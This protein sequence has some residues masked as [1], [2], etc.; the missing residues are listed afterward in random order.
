[1]SEID[2][3]FKKLCLINS[4]SGAMATTDEALNS[5][6][7]DACQ[8]GADALLIDAV[9]STG[10]RVSGMSVSATTYGIAFTDGAPP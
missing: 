2:R 4:T 1:V 8:C 5:A 6:R 9:S 10:S 3:P 7:R